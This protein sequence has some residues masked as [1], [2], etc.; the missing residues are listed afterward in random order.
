MER[1]RKETARRTLE[2]MEAMMKLSMD[3][4]IQSY[5]M[6]S[7]FEHDEMIHPGILKRIRNAQFDCWVQPFPQARRMVEVAM[8]GENA[9]KQSP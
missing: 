8:E 1:D 3:A 9:K 7:F 2:L 5:S 4:M 6:L